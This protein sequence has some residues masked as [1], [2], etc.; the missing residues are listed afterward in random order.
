[1]QTPFAAAIAQLCDEK[2]ISK[3]KVI[4]TIKAAIRAAYKK[5][6]G[7]RDMNVDVD[8]D[9]NSGNAT[10]F[11]VK[12][13]VKAIENDELE[14][15][16]VEAKKYKP[17]A[18]VGDEI[19]IDVTPAGYG[20][21]AAQSAKQVIIQRIQEAERDVMYEVFKDRENELINSMVHR[22][23]GDYV[24]VNLDSKIT[25]LLPREEQIPG[26]RYFS[27]QRLK[28]YLDKV[29]KTTK[30]PQLLISRRHP[31]LVQKL[32]ELEIPEVK[33]GLVLVKAI[34]REPGVR[35]KVAVASSDPKI[36]PIGSCVGQ[37]GVRVQAVM[38]ELNNERIDIILF[39][40]KPDQYIR[41]ALS[42]AKISHI[43][44]NDNSRRASIYV[45]TDQ[46]PLAIGK[47]GQNVRLASIL[48]GWELDIKDLSELSP[49]E[50]EKKVVEH[51]ADL[52]S[53]SPE[54][55]KKL[56]AA[57]LTAVGQLKGLGE[58]DIVGLE[59]ITKDEAKTIVEAVK[60]VA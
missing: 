42:P 1:M 53:L 54:I 37:K 24:Y 22:V 34:A 39:S 4:D 49:K 9:D 44:L 6:Y 7:T 29:I 20:R 10:V 60:E 48:T 21:I 5:D 14:M 40:D 46:R 52:E 41:A 3:D 25:T 32:M 13:V 27:G 28:L 35:C 59:G 23:D 15:T 51:V 33:S 30:G 11:A 38:D 2:G 57:N 12:T 43:T 8:L 55:I 36:D 26:E 31:K 17:A 50:I 18:K 47:Q 56:E 45:A 16:L 58:K 19:R